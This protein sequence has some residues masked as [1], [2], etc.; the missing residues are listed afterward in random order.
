MWWFLLIIGV[1][2][3]IG[4]FWLHRSADEMGEKYNN[5]PALIHDPA[6]DLFPNQKYAIVGILCLIQGSSQTS[7]YSEEANNIVWSIIFSLGLSR[8]DVEKYLGST[9][10][11]SPQYIVRRINDSLL[12]IRDKQYLEGIYK[13]CSRLADISGDYEMK[14]LVDDVFREVFRLMSAR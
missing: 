13:K 3:L 10:N 14:I 12:E 11:D 6:K 8:K 9:M 5:R 1:L 2:G 4:Y 7:A